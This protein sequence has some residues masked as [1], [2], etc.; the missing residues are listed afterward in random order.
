M[1]TNSFYNRLFDFKS[2]KVI[3]N[4]VLF[5]IFWS[6]VLGSNLQAQTNEKF[7]VITIESDRGSNASVNL[8]VETEIDQGNIIPITEI[9]NINRSYT[10]SLFAGIRGT[11]YVPFV[12]EN[13]PY[14]FSSKEWERINELWAWNSYIAEIKTDQQIYIGQIL[15]LN[16]SV[17]YLWTEYG[18]FYNPMYADRFVQNIIPDSVVYIKILKEGYFKGRFKRGAAVGAISGAAV[19]VSLMFYGGYV[20][21]LPVTIFWG[22]GSFSILALIKDHPRG[23]IYE[24]QP[25]HDFSTSIP[26]LNKYATFPTA[27][28]VIFDIQKNERSE[29]SEIYTKESFKNLE[30]V[31]PRMAEVFRYPRFSISFYG[32]IFTKYPKKNART[33]GSGFGLGY[34][35]N[36]KLGVAYQRISN[37]DDRYG[38]FGTGLAIIEEWMYSYE[39]TKKISNSIYFNYYPIS[40][41]KYFIHRLNISIGIGASLNKLK[42]E[43]SYTLGT[44]FGNYGFDGVVNINYKTSANKPGVGLRGEMEMFLYKRF[45]FFTMIEKTFI[46]SLSI[47][48]NKSIHPETGELLGIDAHK[49]NMSSFSLMYGVRLHF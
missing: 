2:D 17:I 5:F 46:P 14:G 43:S 48:E 38:S 37:Y 33:S 36:N 12:K 34:K 13:P 9:N 26:K 30:S 39:Y 41:D 32:E 1:N 45:S 28:P 10:D 16:D 4:I 3:L 47:P 25:L 44:R 6:H 20:L 27:L 19:G 21:I 42:T 11:E 29:L 18:S 23:V 24:W 7:V 49:V 22:V 35:V 40:A 8:I 31:S 15:H